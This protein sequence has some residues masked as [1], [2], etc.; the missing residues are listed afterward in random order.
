MAAKADIFIPTSKQPISL[1]SCLDSLNKQSTKDFRIIIVAKVDL[2]EIKDLIKKYNLN[3]VYLVQKNR[4][5]VNA[6]NT[7]LTKSRSTIFIRIDDD[8]TVSKNWLKEIL[9]TFDSSKNIAAVT[10]PTILSIK[11]LK[12][13]DSMAYVTSKPKRNLISRLLDKLYYQYIMEG[14]ARKIGLFFKSGA[15]SIGSNFKSSLS[16]KRQAVQNLEACNFAVKRRYIFKFGGFDRTFELGLGEYHEADLAMKIRS[17]NKKIIFNPKAYVNHNV[18]FD[19]PSVR[20]DS[21][22]RI[23]NFIVFYRR[24]IGFRNIDY[25][26]RFFSNVLFQN[27]YYV[28]KF[29]KS[30]K[31]SFL[32]SIPG[33]F[34]GLLY[35]NN[36]D[37]RI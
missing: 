37:E 28:Y 13:R 21:Y 6:A 15:F 32:G 2:Q 3:I 26:L 17:V 4:G 10:G 1:K 33:T 35:R 7:A 29:I 9:A 34:S 12:S 20:P 27:G 30:G 18:E 16:A 23:K 11:G 31:L 22:N 19:S 14:K 5:L 8:V 24:H 25:F 36:K